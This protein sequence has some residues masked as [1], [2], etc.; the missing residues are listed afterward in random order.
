MYKF[1]K[2]EQYGR[3][4]NLRIYGVPETTSYRQDGENVRFKITEALEISSDHYT[5]Q[6]AHRLG[7]PKNK[8]RH[9]I[10]RAVSYKKRCEFL[11]AKSKLK[12]INIKVFILL[13]I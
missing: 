1:Y 2:F 12:K 6:K 11:N 10:V 8:P 3:H 13:K 9:I 7:K 5:I 4:E